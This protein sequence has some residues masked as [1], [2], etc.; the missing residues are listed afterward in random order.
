MDNPL[1]SQLIFRRLD[2]PG[3]KANGIGRLNESSLHAAVKAWYALPGDEFEV[4]VDGFVVDLVRDDLLIEIQ[5]GSF[6]S[7]K[8]KLLALVGR[9]K[10]LLVYPIAAGKWI[11]KID[12][13]NGEFIGRRKSPKKGKVTDLFDELVRIPDLINNDNF[14]IDVLMIQVD[15]IRC[16]DGQ[17]SWH[18]KGVS[19]RDTELIQVLEHVRFR[20][21]R[22]FLALLPDDLD[23]PFTNKTLAQH[24]GISVRQSTKMSYCLRKM[25]VIVKAGK[26]GNV[27]LFER[28]A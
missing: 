7:I 12:P 16:D 25:G 28:A 20:D 13:S 10:V 4:N 17:G 1:R 14:Q 8:K 3:S 21:R 9:H 18:R 15:E 23:Q 22:D 24:L 19:I 2:L 26:K 5:T 27:L 6:S 11:V